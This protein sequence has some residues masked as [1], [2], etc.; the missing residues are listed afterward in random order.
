M[1]LDPG[2]Y[3]FGRRHHPRNGYAITAFSA[4]CAGTITAGQTK[5]CTITADDRAPSRGS[6]QQAADGAWHGAN[7]SID[8]TAQDD[9]SGLADPRRRGVLALDVGGGRHRGRDAATG[10]RQVCDVAGNCDTAGPIAGQQDRPQGADAL[11]PG[12]QDGGRDLARGRG[13]ELLGV[14][15]RRRR[16][17]PD[18]TCAPASGSVFAIGT[19]RRVHGDRP[20]RQRRGGAFTVTVR[21]AKQQLARLVQDVVSCI[22][23]CRRRSRRSCSRSSSRC[24]AFDPG[25]PAQRRAVC[26][27]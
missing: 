9:G 27:R 11:A 15:H 5:T 18:V 7:V 23:D 22:E 26:T 14:G 1:T 3:G 25:N 6:H 16:P 17:E 10:T 4:D 21:G 8:C 13:G 24:C 2:D 19:T 12:R 20:R